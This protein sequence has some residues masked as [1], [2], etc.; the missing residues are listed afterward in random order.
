MFFLF[1]YSLKQTPPPHTHTYLSMSQNRD[2]DTHDDV[3]SKKIVP[4]CV[5]L[6]C[7]KVLLL[8]DSFERCVWVTL[9]VMN[10]E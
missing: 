6:G 1:I 8:E 10:L 2:R 7:R 4:H 5:D 3:Y 9:I